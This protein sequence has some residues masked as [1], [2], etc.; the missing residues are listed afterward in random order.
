MD[1]RRKAI[2]SILILILFALSLAAC[3]NSAEGS[4]I[5][6]A[7]PG[8]GLPLEGDVCPSIV[9]APGDTVTWTNQSKAQRQ[10][11][12]QDPDL[13]QLFDSGVLNRGDSFSFTFPQAGTYSYTCW[14]G[15]DPPATLTVQP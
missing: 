9:I 14:S 10:I 3:Q 2:L 15:Q 8:I 7:K 11:T 4:P 5:I 6:P 1:F 13:T 12:G